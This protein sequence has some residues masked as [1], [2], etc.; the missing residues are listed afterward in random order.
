[1]KA[2]SDDD[3]DLSDNAYEMRNKSAEMCYSDELDGN[4]NASDSEG[5]ADLREQMKANRAQ[6]KQAPRREYRQEMDTNIFRIDLATL[7]DKAELATGDPIFCIHCKAVFNFHSKVEKTLEGGQ[8]W[9]CEFCNTVNKVDLEDDE[10][11]QTNKVNYIMEAAAQVMDKQAQGKKDIA[12]IFCV[13][14]SGSMCISKPVK[15]KHNLKGDRTKELQGLMKFS[16]GSD[17]FLKG[18]RG[19]TYVSRM[20]CLQA[21]IS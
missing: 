16:D 18:D 17:Q 1:M 15:G 2:S 21:A 8:V 19:V 10:K 14:S 13:D 4:L 3:S 6:W 11:P 5:E 20:Q 12:Q 7:K 9:T